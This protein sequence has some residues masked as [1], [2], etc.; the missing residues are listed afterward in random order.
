MTW[1]VMTMRCPKCNQSC[2]VTEVAFREDSM[3][4]LEAVC[5][6]CKNMLF[7]EEHVSQTIPKPKFNLETWQPTG[8]SN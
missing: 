4:R 5:L 2:K 8:L 6:K 7:L 1:H 3:V